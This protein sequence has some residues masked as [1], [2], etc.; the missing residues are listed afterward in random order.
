MS[1][2]TRKGDRGS[3]RLFSGETVSKDDLR[4]QCYGTLDELQAQLG[5]ARA[6]MRDPELSCSVYGIQQD[7]SVACTELASSSESLSR[8]KRRIEQENTAKLEKQID[9][10]VAEYGLPHRFIVPGRSPDS[11]AVHVAR[12]VCRR[13]ERLIVMLNREAKQFD[14]LLTYFNRLS[15]FLFVL[16]WSLEVSFVVDSVANELAKD[17]A[18]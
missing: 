7:L 16:S 8:L 17:G 4:V 5:M 11:A 9:A 14:E 3:T 13:A 1:I 15:D 10:L 2:Y 12:T 18:K 6:F